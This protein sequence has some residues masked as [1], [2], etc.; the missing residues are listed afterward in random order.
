MIKNKG[1]GNTSQIEVIN[2]RTMSNR[3]IRY[4]SII[5]HII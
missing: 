1:T 5:Y 2:I 3:M 4:T